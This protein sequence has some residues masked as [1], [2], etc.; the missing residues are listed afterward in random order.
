MSHASLTCLITGVKLLAREAYSA[1]GRSSVADEAPEDHAFLH[2]LKDD[3]SNEGRG[4]PMASGASHLF[5]L[6]SK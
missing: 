5:S 1:I 4:H 2:D 3:T 6:F